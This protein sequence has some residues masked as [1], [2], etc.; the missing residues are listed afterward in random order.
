MLRNIF[1][2]VFVCQ[3]GSEFILRL[4]VVI[5]SMVVPDFSLVRWKWRKV[6]VCFTINYLVMAE[7]VK[8]WTC[9]TI[10]DEIWLISNNKINAHEGFLLGSKLVG[11]VIT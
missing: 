2:N 3:F 7:R 6:D 5:G 9:S 8:R 11:S 10:K 4:L 1:V